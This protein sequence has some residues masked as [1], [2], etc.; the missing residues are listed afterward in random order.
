M[1]PNVLLVTL[2]QLRADC[3]S[4]AGHPIVRTPALDALAATGVR[5]ARHYSQAAPCAPGRASLYTGMYQMNHRVVGNGTPLAA[6]FDNVALLARRA[7]YAPALF[8]YTDQAIDPRLADGPD[9]PRLST[10]NGVLAGL[11]PVVHLPD[12]QGPWVEWLD[13]LGY[14]TSSGPLALLA[15]EDRRPEQHSVGAFLTDAVIGWLEARSD[16]DEPWFVHVSHLRPHPPYS[17]AGQWSTA[18]DPTRVGTPIAPAGEPTWFH[19]AVLAHE[20]AVAPTRP[21]ELARMRAQY[22]GMVGHIDHQVGRLLDA[23]RRLGHWD[24]TVVIVTADHGE[25]LGDHG[26]KEKVGYWEPSY[27][28]PCIVRDPRHPASQGVVIDRFTENVDIM[29]TIADAIG[30]PVPVQCDGYPLTPFLRGAEPPQWRTAAHWEYDWRSMLVRDLGHDWPWQRS[31]EAQHL[32]VIRSDEHAYVQFGNG[33]WLCFD[34]ATDPTWRTEVRDPNVVLP[35]AQAMLV[36]RSHHTDRELTDLVLE[37][38][39]VGRWPPVPWR[40]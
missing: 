1:R 4:A 13:G 7:G 20:Q 8:G 16:Q 33:A 29:P 40:A 10:Y 25:M 19:Q 3:L 23:I 2:D 30:E 5:F 27:A 18:Y 31:L 14:D 12:D 28:I 9:D 6:R 34:L 38:G 22:F 36:W 35:L 24:D 11:D 37:D 39:G 15:T 32:T 21:E 26:L 17:A